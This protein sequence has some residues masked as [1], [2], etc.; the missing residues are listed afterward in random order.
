MTPTDA[1]CHRAAGILDQLAEMLDPVH[2]A[3]QI[4]EPIDKAAMGFDYSEGEALSH[5]QFLET[6]ARFLRHL[7]AQAFPRGRQL[8]L[9]QA[10]DEAV[11]LLQQGYRGVFYSGY[12]EAF[13]DAANPFHPGM[14]TVLLK[15]ADLVRARQREMYLDWV[16][17]RY[18]DPAD[19]RMKRAV[20]ALL[21]DRC[22][23]WLPDRVQ[24]CPPAQLADY[25]PGLLRLYLARP[26]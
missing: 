13:L 16:I 3:R 22:R 26:N 6:V 2:T 25:I 8:S 19:W 11:A 17:A 5:R 9:A 20:T 10:R 4:D 15:V 18:I 24:D 14:E 23:S 12:D 7:Y 1:L 21:L